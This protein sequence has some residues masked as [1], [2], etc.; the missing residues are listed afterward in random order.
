MPRR[1]RVMM[2]TI[3]Q[4]SVKDYAKS[5]CLFMHNEEMHYEEF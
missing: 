4:R 3:N 1:S 5:S 2:R